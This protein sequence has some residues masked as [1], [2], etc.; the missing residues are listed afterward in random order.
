M[1]TFSEALSLYNEGKYMEAFQILKSIEQTDDVKYYLALCYFYGNGCKYNYQK[2]FDLFATLAISK[3]EKSFYYLAYQYEYG[4]GVQ[5]NIRQAILWYKYSITTNNPNSMYRLGYLYSKLNMKKSLKYLDMAIS[6]K[7]IKAIMLKVKLIEDN[8]E[9]LKLYQLGVDLGDEKAIYYLSKYYID[10]DI[11]NPN[12]KNYLNLSIKLGNVYSY[13]LY[14]KALLEGKVLD[15]DPVLG[16]KILEAG[17]RIGSNE[18]KLMLADHYL[19]GEYIDKSIYKAIKYYQD[20]AKSND[21]RALYSLAKIYYE[22]KEFKD[23]DRLVMFYLTLIANLKDADANYY[24]G[25]MYEKGICTKVDLNKS[26]EFYKCACDLEH[27]EAARVLLRFKKT[28]NNSYII[29][30]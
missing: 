29:K 4:L 26:Y 21:K 15:F 20:V 30:E 10:N 23:N 19:N 24:C 1:H 2:S 7:H 9:K 22:N 25:L 16:I 17:A 28:F 14:A 6:Q 11:K 3:Y 8:D 13:P 27:K 18:C 5:R 12:L